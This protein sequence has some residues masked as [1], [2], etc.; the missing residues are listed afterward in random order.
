MLK[1]DLTMVIYSCNLFSD[2]WDAHVK[3]LNEN[4]ADRN[5]DTFIV[6]DK[7]TNHHYNG[8]QIISTGEGNELSKRIAIMLPFIK[9][10]YVLVTLDDYFP[11][12]PI[13]T[14]RIEN[15]IKAMEK[16]GLDYIRLFKRPNS[17]ARI[18]GYKDL[19]KINLNSKRD[20]NYQVNLYSGIW[21]KSFI[22]TTAIGNRNAWRY[23]LSLTPIARQEG[24]YCAM[25]KGKEYETLDVVRKGK[26]LHRANRYLKK[27]NLYHGSRMLIKWKEEWKINLMTFLKDILPQ[28]TIDL[29]KKR[30]KEKGH[31][32]YSDQTGV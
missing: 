29:A 20:S 13:E 1:N 11:I 4:W 9:T 3:L 31:S 27:H 16:E 25:S 10:K 24:L 6:T 28:K 19:Y 18:E 26:L 5:I 32:F 2:L 14:K 7:E 22:A 17:F 23:E 30:M 15:L 21:R 12:Y 8:V